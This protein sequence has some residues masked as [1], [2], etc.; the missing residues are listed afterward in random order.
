MAAIRS[1]DTKPELVLR[2]T[3]HRRGVRYRLHVGNLPG[4]PDL[5]LPGHKAVIFV[6]GCFFHGHE[7][8]AFRWPTTR[9]DFWRNKIV[10]NRQRD[11]SVTDALLGSG[12]RVLTIW[13]CAIRGRGR[14]SP[15]W[16]GRQAVQWL[17]SG[18]PVGLITERKVQ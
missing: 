9:V 16:V 15:D 18:L 6:H 14:F 17:S 8:S 11:A 13:E 1:V 3:L 12:W 7:C 2:K 4:R 5:V 10:G